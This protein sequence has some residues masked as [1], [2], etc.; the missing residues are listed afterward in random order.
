[1]GGAT[2]IH[3]IVQEIDFMSESHIYQSAKTLQDTASQHRR[4]IHRNPELAFQ[5]LQTAEYVVKELEALGFEVKRGFGKTGLVAS[6]AGVS[7]GP[8]FLLR[9]DMDAVGEGKSEPGNRFPLHHPCMDINKNS[10][11]IAA[12]LLLETCQQLANSA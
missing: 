3:R 12:A 2:A 10:L 11:I 5:E 8:R 9:F 4:H 7:S 1:M 6:M